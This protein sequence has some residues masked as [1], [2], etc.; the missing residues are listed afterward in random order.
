MLGAR[1][2]AQGYRSVSELVNCPS[3][4][5][6]QVI[7]VKYYEDFQMRIPRAEVNEVEQLVIR[8]AHALSPGAQVVT[9]GSC[10][11][12]MVWQPSSL[13]HV[14]LHLTLLVQPDCGDIDI[15]ITHPDGVSHA[16][17]FEP[18]VR[19]LQRDKCAFVDCCSRRQD[20][21]SFIAQGSH[22]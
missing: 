16:T 7:G 11:R 20:V 12:L 5:K 9:C 15:L 13:A 4:T 2:Y 21:G 8:A 18:L 10:R 19:R 17:L 1:W 6:M 14:L 22:R 3:L